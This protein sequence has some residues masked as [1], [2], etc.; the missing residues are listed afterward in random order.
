MRYILDLNNVEKGIDLWSIQSLNKTRFNA[1]LLEIRVMT[2]EWTL[3]KKGTLL[4]RL[5]YLGCELV[6]ENE[7]QVSKASLNG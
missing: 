2:R 7:S 1:M 5:K 3:I 6:M 4:A